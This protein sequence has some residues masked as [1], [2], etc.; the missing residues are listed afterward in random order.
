MK[1]PYA[2]GVV[3]LIVA[4]VLMQ[5]FGK[6][7][8]NIRLLYCVLEAFGYYTGYLYTNLT[9]TLWIIL[10][11]LIF[12]LVYFAFKLMWRN[13][14]ILTSKLFT[15]KAQI[16]PVCI[17]LVSLL[18][19]FIM[20]S[21]HRLTL[22]FVSGVDAIIIQ[23]R[24]APLVFDNKYNKNKTEIV[25]SK[26]YVFLQFDDFNSADEEFRVKIINLNDPLKEYEIPYLMSVNSLRIGYTIDI[27]DIPALIDETDLRF[28]IAIFNGTNSKIINLYFDAYKNMSY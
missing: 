3:L 10:S 5:A 18:V 23:D 19:C 7:A 13:K 1:K 15:I 8:E 21:I 22:R 17:F 2:C 16:L 4:C 20:P 25:S 27:E 6:S 9:I 11:V 28:K 14:E 26:T 12:A 24:T